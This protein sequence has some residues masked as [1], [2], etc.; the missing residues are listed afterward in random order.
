MRSALA[1]A[2]LI[3]MCF[4][5]AY[6]QGFLRIYPSN[7]AGPAQFAPGDKGIFLGPSVSVELFYRENQTGAYR[8]GLTPGVGYGIKYSKDLSKP[9][10]YIVALDL[11]VQ[12]G[13]QNSEGNTTGT[14]NS[15]YFNIDF[16]PVVSFVNGWFGIGYGPRFKLGLNGAKDKVY[17]IFTFGVRR[18]IN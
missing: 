11:F 2:A 7:P 3:L 15:N 4:N 12:G 10:N 16:L 14:T 13:F 6:S 17:T 1:L 9:N 8:A 5:T 18:P